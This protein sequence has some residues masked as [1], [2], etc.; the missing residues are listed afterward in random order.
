LATIAY[1]IGTGSGQDEASTFYS[2][3]KN[4]ELLPKFGGV[5]IS[6][7]FRDVSTQAINDARTQALIDSRGETLWIPGPNVRVTSDADV[8]K[9][10]IGD[11]VSYELHNQ[12]NV[13]GSFRLMSRTI[14]V[15]ENNTETVSTK[16]V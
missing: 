13:R 9:Y 16:F 4:D 6:S 15:A 14:E 3:K 12:M 5:G 10:D 1:G 2:V 11:R 8:D 7:L